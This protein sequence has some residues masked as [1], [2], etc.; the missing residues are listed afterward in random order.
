MDNN[1]DS[2]TKIIFRSILYIQ[3]FR[4]KIVCIRSWIIFL[5]PAFSLSLSFFLSYFL[6]SLSPP[7]RRTATRNF[8]GFTP[9]SRKPQWNGISGRARSR[10]QTSPLN[11]L[12]AK[13]SRSPFISL[14]P[15]SAPPEGLNPVLRFLPSLHSL[16]STAKRIYTLD[17]SR[18]HREREREREREKERERERERE[19]ENRCDPFSM[20]KRDRVRSRS[21]G[22]HNMRQDERRREIKGREKERGKL[23]GADGKVTSLIGARCR[24][25]NC[26]RTSLCSR[27]R[28]TRT[29][30]W[31]RETAGNTRKRKEE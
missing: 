12:H 8:P 15:F 28:N 14:H 21:G 19:K 18:D 30:W 25:G 1:F 20:G 17:R 31:L 9:V 6:V 23:R 3:F 26:V 5:V 10:A 11:S 27:V 16:H 13:T 7:N 4:T 29:S 2:L 24:P 22:G